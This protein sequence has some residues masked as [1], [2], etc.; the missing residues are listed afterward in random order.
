MTKKKKKIFLFSWPK[1][2]VVLDY[3]FMDLE[4]TALN[5]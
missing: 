1:L 4:Y 5:E 3:Y 2:S